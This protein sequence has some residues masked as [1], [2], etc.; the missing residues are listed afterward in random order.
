MARRAAA[1]EKARVPRAQAE[2]VLEDKGNKLIMDDTNFIMHVC[3][4]YY[5]HTSAPTSTTPPLSG[6]LI[7][8]NGK[9]KCA[10]AHCRMSD[11]DRNFP[12]VSVH[13][14]ASM[15]TTL[16][17]RKRKNTHPLSD[18]HMLCGKRGLLLL[19]PVGCFLHVLLC[20]SASQTTNR[21]KKRGSRLPPSQTSTT[22][23]STT[24]QEQEQRGPQDDR[25]LG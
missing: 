19:C 16:A 17:E 8:R 22:N 4:G 15:S 10:R 11:S 1:E 7:G 21:R 18:K 23:D 24:S 9:I 3:V 5:G 25:L 12:R 13:P 20:R 6:G 14:C 2:K